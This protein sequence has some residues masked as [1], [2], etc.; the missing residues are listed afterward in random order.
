VETA[1]VKKYLIKK[2]LLDEFEDIPLENFDK[3]SLQV[4]LNQLAMTRSRDR[5]LQIRAYLRDIFFEAVDQ[6]YLRKRS[7]AQGKGSEATPGKRQD[8]ADLGTAE[9]STRRT[10]IARPRA[11]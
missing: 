1:K 10:F 11:P 2:D 5:V 9:E 7:G 4:H 6:D 8:D 3:F